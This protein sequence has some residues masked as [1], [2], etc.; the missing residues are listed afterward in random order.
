MMV[1]SSSAKATIGNTRGVI[2]ALSAALVDK[3]ASTEQKH[4]CLSTLMLLSQD[5]KV[6]SIM[7]RF[8]ELTDALET[9]AIDE[10]PLIR[11]LVCSL[12]VNLNKDKANRFIVGE[13]FLDRSVHIIELASAFDDALPHRGTSNVDLSA[14]LSDM[15]MD[16]C[17]EESVGS[18]D[19]TCVAENYTAVTARANTHDV[20]SQARSKALK[21]LLDLSNMPKL[22]TIMARHDGLVAALL[23]QAGNLKAGDN[24]MIIAILT[25][26][27]RHPANIIPLAGNGSFV[28][29]VIHELDNPD[30][31]DDRR[32]CA[33]FALRNL[34]S[35][36]K[37]QE[38][39][40]NNKRLLRALS[41][42]HS[43]STSAEV[44]IEILR[45]VQNLSNDPSFLLRLPNMPIMKALKSTCTANES[46]DTP[47]E[48]KHLA[49]DIM[50]G[51][52]K[53]AWSSAYTAAQAK[54]IYLG[55]DLDKSFGHKNPA[56]PYINVRRADQ[57]E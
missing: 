20:Y 41:S 53:W 46:S 4:R 52:S 12:L 9:V 45:V 31:N 33:L 24:V 44:R 26:L 35:E 54:A 13:F 2:P 15:T 19:T 8:K 16:R 50:A 18:N 32:K 27:T 6:R 55:E 3:N 38:G 48:E 39:M 47:D 40:I 21:V 34:T 51:I 56:T 1:R 22:T 43:K 25:N 7:L 14:V 37:A 57:W 11:K 17:L 10:S 49:R 30:N 36:P 42:Q 5:K 23:R 28:T 29:I